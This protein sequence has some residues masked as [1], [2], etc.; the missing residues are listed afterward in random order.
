MCRQS[1][2]KL[3]SLL[4][5]R[6]RWWL[7]RPSCPAGGQISSL[8]LCMLGCLA[9]ASL[10]KWSKTMEGKAV[11]NPNLPGWMLKRTA[12][13]SVLTQMT[14]R[15]TACIWGWS[16]VCADW[17]SHLQLYRC[18]MVTSFLLHV[19]PSVSVSLRLTQGVTILSV[20]SLAQFCRRYRATVWFRLRFHVLTNSS[21]TLTWCLSAG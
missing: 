16:C 11:N 21:R 18:E 8:L 1:T 20:H 4:L 2:D 7:L 13:N 10:R 5:E 19:F 6:Y 12:Q 14:N 17:P 9:A 15:V 3:M